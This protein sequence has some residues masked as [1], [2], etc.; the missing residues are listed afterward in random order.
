MSIIIP[1]GGALTITLSPIRYCITQRP[2]FETKLLITS[3]PFIFTLAI[4]EQPNKPAKRA[5][6]NKNPPTQSH[7]NPASNMLAVNGNVQMNRPV[8]K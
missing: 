5:R 6:V 8:N 7:A 1:A 4:E 3:F 2:Q